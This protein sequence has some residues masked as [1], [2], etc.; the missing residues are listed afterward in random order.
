MSKLY[1]YRSNFQDVSGERRD[2]RLLVS[3]CIYASPF[4]DLNDPFEGSVRLPKS[5]SCD[6]WVTPLIQSISNI[7]V[8]S[9]SRQKIGEVFPSNEILWSLYAKFP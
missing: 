8:C 5:V 1:K 9:F 2:T 7:G 4:K 6:Y 3:N